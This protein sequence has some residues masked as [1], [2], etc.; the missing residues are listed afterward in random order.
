MPRRSWRVN[1]CSITIAPFS[2]RRKATWPAGWPCS[3]AT[4]VTS[5][6]STS[7]TR[8]SLHPG[9]RRTSIC[10]RGASSTSCSA[11]SLDGVG[12]ANSDGRTDLS[13]LERDR[14]REPYGLPRRPD[15]VRIWGLSKTQA[16]YRAAPTPEVRCDRCKY[17]FP[18][19]ALG[20]CRLVRGPIRGAATC[21][22]F[23][24]RRA[25]PD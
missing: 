14:V 5:R 20:G 25:N 8:S 6:L 22:E 7:S 2:L 1:S 19:L 12:F 17:M 16:H 11:I 3:R 15:D 10:S 24:P 23:T 9:R 21:D 13:D 18:P 4:N